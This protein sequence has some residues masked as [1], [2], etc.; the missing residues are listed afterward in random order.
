MNVDSRAGRRYSKVRKLLLATCAGVGV[1]VA[2]G[3]SGAFAAGGG[4]IGDIV[5]P[6]TAGLGLNLNQTNIN[7]LGVQNRTGNAIG[8]TVRQSNSVRSAT[9]VR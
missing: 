8:T 3:T 6:V 5:A 2:I 9:S 1:W 7:V 4:L